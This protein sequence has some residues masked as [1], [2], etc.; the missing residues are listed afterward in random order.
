MDLSHPQKHLSDLA[1]RPRGHTHGSARSAEPA[2]LPTE[3]QLPGIEEGGAATAR[4]VAD[5]L[6]GMTDRF[7]LDEHRRLFDIY[8]GV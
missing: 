4:I 7:A 6:A 8:A 5:Y 3:W 2:C 1:H